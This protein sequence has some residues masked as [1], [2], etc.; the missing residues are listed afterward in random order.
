MLN[1]DNFAITL[2][3]AVQNLRARPDAVDEHKRDLRALVA[4]TRLGAVTLVREGGRLVVCGHPVGPMLPGIATLASQM[5]A[6]DVAEIRI[7]RAAMPAD[8][9]HLL[10]GL[11]GGLGTFADGR[12]LDERL[13]GADVT[14]VSVTI[15]P[16]ASP[17]PEPG[18][19]EPGH[20]A[21]IATAEM[22]AALDEATALPKPDRLSAAIADLALDPQR[23]DVL[24]RATTAAE[25]VH[26]EIQAGR[27]TSALASAAELVRLESRLPEGGSRRSMAIVLNRLLTRP[28]LQ[29]AATR[30]RGSEP[31]DPTR[32]LLRRGGEQATEVLLERLVQAE[33]IGERRHYFDLL[34][35]AADGLRQAIQMLG[36]SEWYVVRNVADLLGELRVAE[37]V[38][39]LARTLRHFDARVRR[40]AALA[41]AR[42]GTPETL[43]HLARILRDDD[44]ELRLA[45]AGA[46]GGREMET[47]SMPLVL[48][49]ERE[50]DPRVA[51]ELCRALGRVG[52]PAAL[53]ALTRDALPPRWRWWRHRP[54]RRLRAIEGL[55]LAGGPAAIGTL[56]ALLEDR[57]REVRRAAREALEDLD[58]L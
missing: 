56:E 52:S 44:A 18:E 16:P 53:Q 11:A 32:L 26:A 57:D 58:V 51:L 29:E 17:P 48:A 8:L 38:A 25:L 27:V 40:S 41:L 49:G 33:G 35:G 46:I 24:D 42:I 6:H 15:V 14:S 10:R 39:P 19:R 5:E 9:L 31:G 2:G 43:D 21:A 23:E 28:L 37:A 1:Y 34:R 54:G 7:A 4:L 55:K 50:R 22:L 20:T 36:H 13:R 47:L 12:G 30:S 3:R 45:V